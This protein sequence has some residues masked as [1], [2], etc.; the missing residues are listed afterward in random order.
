M[1]NIT[2]YPTE[3]MKLYVVDHS[4]DPCSLNELVRDNTDTEGKCCISVEEFKRISALEIGESMSCGMVEIKRV[5]PELWVDPAY[6]GG[7]A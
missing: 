6:L 1:L 3:I 4:N 2:N 5:D 7:S